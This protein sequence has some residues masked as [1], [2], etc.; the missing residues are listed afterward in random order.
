MHLFWQ[1][2]PALLYAL[3]FLIGCYYALEASWLILFP[4]GILF[5]TQAKLSK[6][7]LMRLGLAS[8]TAI[9]AFVYVKTQ[10]ILP[11]L[12]PQGAYGSIEFDIQSLS[13]S[14]THFG[15]FWV[16]KGKI[17]KF[18][19]DSKNPA[20]EGEN[21]P[22]RLSLPLRPDCE[23][24]A[25]NK[26]Y[27]IRGRL[28]E[29]KHGHYAFFMNKEEP[30]I[31]LANT[32]SLAEFRYTAKNALAYQIR[33]SIEDQQPAIFLTGMATGEFDDRQMLYEFGRFGLQHIMAISGFHFS[34]VSAVLSMLLGMVLSKRNAILFL[35]FILSLYFL[36]LG[37]NPSIMR[38]WMT[39]LIALVGFVIEKRH[40][41]LNSLGIAMLAILIYNPLLCLNIGFQ[42]SFLATGGILLLF[43]GFDLFL[44]RIFLKRALSQLILMDK[45]NQH[46]YFILCCCRQALALTLAVNLVS[47]PLVLYYFHKFSVMSLLYNLFFPFLVSVSLFFLIIGG[48]LSLVLPSLGELIHHINTHYTQFILNYTYNIPST[49]DVVWR[50]GSYPAALLIVQLCLLFYLGMWMERRAELRQEERQD[51]A[52]L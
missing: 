2:H 45:V 10:Y 14:K 39:V 43:H 35:I 20:D 52:F 33:H 24:P 25:A 36:F 4:L 7:L 12:P 41:G 17:R 18:Y 42:F 49:V 47:T 34:I 29:Q 30:W 9:A 5:G 40:R 8:L 22:C 46:G 44:Q 32:W 13:S 28:Q 6:D 23:R 19:P 16:Y 11:K 51:F 37:D 15:K 3:F 21:I 27:L 38:A 1:K 48:C 26:S 31:P 50:V